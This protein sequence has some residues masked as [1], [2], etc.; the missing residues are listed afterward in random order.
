MKKPMVLSASMSDAWLPPSG[1]TESHRYKKG[2]LL[3]ELPDHFYPVLRS[4]GFSLL[5][6]DDEFFTTCEEGKGQW[7]WEDF[8]GRVSRIRSEGFNATFFPHWHW[9]PPWYERTKGFVGT[10]CLSHNRAVPCLSVWSPGILPWFNRC[11]KELRNQYADDLS[12]IYL[13]I[14]GDFGEAMFFLGDEIL[15]A[16][17]LAYFR[18]LHDAHPL[19]R[20]FWCN[21]R[22]AKADFRKFLARK[23]GT[24]SDLN[25]HWNCRYSSFATA[26]YPRSVVPRHKRQWLDFVEWYHDSMTVFCGEVAGLYRK[27][28]PD[29]RLM[30][31]MGG[32]LETLQIGQDNTGLPRAMKKH[33]VTIRSTA[34]GVC[35]FR[36]ALPV[37]ERFSRTY[38]IIKR[39]SSACKFYKLPFWLEA[40]YPP[41]M[42][43]RGTVA[44]LFEVICCAAE[45]Y[46]EWALSVVHNRKAYEKYKGLLVQD[47]PKVDVAVFYPTTYQRLRPESSYPERFW[48]G[49]SDIRRIIDYDVLDE[50]LIGDGALRG[51]RFL[52]IFEG[53]IMEAR[54]LA[55][56]TRWVRGGGGVVSYDMGKVLS[57]EGDDAAYMKLFGFT[58]TTR[59]SRPDKGSARS[60]VS[61]GFLR[62]FKSCKRRY[63]R[64]FYSDLSSNVTSLARG[65]KGAHVWACKTGRGYGIFFGGGWEAK[66]ALY[67]VIRDTVYNPQMLDKSLKSVKS[68]NN[69]WD[70]L[71]ETLFSD[72]VVFLNMT[73][74]PIHRKVGR[75]SARVD[76]FSIKE[77]TF[78]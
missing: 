44:R 10:R 67:E 38:P 75:K 5:Q 52:I 31:P 63:D 26:R 25:L 55:A 30:L 69:V 27:Y 18:G 62:H 51:Y 59:R 72:R 40:P 35:Q 36:T 77:V 23:Y 64:Y 29:I 60:V 7:N 49:A 22:F 9:P 19:H 33:G 48:V 6:V 45:G 46:Y 61:T 8:D 17:M 32:G 41:K 42:S 16:K 78:K 37:P 54:T 12:A 1:K 66:E 20:D 74:K 56:I 58:Q 50:R 39:I 57:V 47:K 70:G 14:H 2:E 3:T 11:I 21:D 76:P 53:D 68:F 65:E 4:L 73:A 71:F 24:V 15:G 43:Y 28:F 13:G 34:G